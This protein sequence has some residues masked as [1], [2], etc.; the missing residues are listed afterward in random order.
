MSLYIMLIII[1]MHDVDL[2]ELKKD[3]LRKMFTDEVLSNPAAPAKRVYIKV[4]SD[5]HRNAA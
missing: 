2:G 5:E 1:T 4:A 3:E